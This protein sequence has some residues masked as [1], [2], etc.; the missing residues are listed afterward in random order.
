MAGSSR[1]SNA[2]LGLALLGAPHPVAQGT[3]ATPAAQATDTSPADSEPKKPAQSVPPGWRAELGVFGA[4]MPSEGRGLR[5]AHGVRLGAGY[6]MLSFGLEY[7][8]YR[9]PWDGGFSDEFEM[10]VPYVAVNFDL[11]TALRASLE[12]AVG[13]G[14]EEYSDESPIV[15]RARAG[16]Q[17]VQH[18]FAVGPFVGYSHNFG[19]GYRDAYRDGTPVPFGFE[20]GGTLSVWLF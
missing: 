17:F 19:E 12:A 5:H 16:I 9:V 15:P 2:L 20:L 4:W 14:S 18:Y 7:S 13:F 1:K 8:L 3:D 6:S 10:A 11:G